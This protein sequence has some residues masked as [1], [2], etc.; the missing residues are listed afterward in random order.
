[1]HSTVIKIVF[2]NWDV[3]GIESFEFY[4]MRFLSKVQYWIASERWAGGIF[5]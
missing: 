2:L 4:E 1:M 5:S 3:N